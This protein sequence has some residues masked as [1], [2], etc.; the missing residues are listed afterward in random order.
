VR[1][2]QGV[3][4]LEDNDRGDALYP[5]VAMNAQGNAVA[6]WYQT[7]EIPLDGVRSIWFNYYTAA[8][9]G[10]D[11]VVEYDDQTGDGID[12]TSIRIAMDALGNAMAVWWGDGNVWSKRYTPS[13]GWDMAVR[14]NSAEADLPALATNNQGNAMVMWSEQDGNL[15][16][17]YY[18]PSQGWVSAAVLVAT[19]NPS[20]PYEPQVAMDA[21]G[22]AVAVWTQGT[23]ISESRFTQA[24]AWEPAEPMPAVLPPM[25]GNA[26]GPQVAMNAQGN[27]TAVWLQSDGIRLNLVAS[28][29]E[30]LIDGSWHWN[31][32]TLIEDNDTSAMHPEVVMDAGGNAI[33][34]WEQ[35]EGRT[36]LWSNRYVVGENL[37]REW[38]NAELLETNDGEL[39]GEPAFHIAMG[40]TDAV[41]VWSQSERTSSGACLD[42]CVHAWSKRYTPSG[43][44]TAELLESNDGLA[45]FPQVAM[46]AGD[47]T[48]AVWSESAV[49]DEPHYDIWS[50]PVR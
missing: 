6:V 5:K 36:H 18:T 50:R 16:S 48:V 40:E 28:R 14:L 21:Q 12:G 13:V 19:S 42:G 9:W 38:E 31:D 37:D 11:R 1:D 45:E 3:A 8:G 32:V 44:E 43:W 33:V 15:W 25:T 49:T 27:A 34:V 26:Y 46:G 4:L 35:Y 41:V 10:T 20:T 17:N 7:E 39:H 24:G 29:S 23:G 22:N 2:H 47:Q 30:V